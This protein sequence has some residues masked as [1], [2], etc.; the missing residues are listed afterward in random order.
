MMVSADVARVGIAATSKT[1]SPIAAPATIQSSWI[2]KAD[3]IQALA[4][5]PTPMAILKNDT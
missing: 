2:E 1:E 5:A 3:T 4:D